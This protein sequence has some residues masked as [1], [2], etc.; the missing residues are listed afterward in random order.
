MQVLRNVLL[1]L[2]AVIVLGA[3]YTGSMV[4]GWLLALLTFGGIVFVVVMAVLTFIT[5]LLHTLWHHV[6]SSKK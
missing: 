5:Y 6:F 2:M 3:C 1:G 4:L